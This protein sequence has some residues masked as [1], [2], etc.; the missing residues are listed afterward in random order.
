MRAF[1]LPQPEKLDLE[2]RAAAAGALHRG[3]VELEAGRLGVSR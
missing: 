3:I 2:R 1:S